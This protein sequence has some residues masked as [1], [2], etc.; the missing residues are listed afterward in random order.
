MYN[1][2]FSKTT[3]PN[4]N[5]ISM[6]VTLVDL[7]KICDFGAD[8]RFSLATRAN[9]AIWLDELKFVFFKSIKFFF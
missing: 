4:Q 7:I 6:N 9:N 1:S 8:P 3:W 2:I 5:K